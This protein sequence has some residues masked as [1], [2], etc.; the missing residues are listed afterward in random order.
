[1][2]CE[3]IQNFST[4]SISKTKN[5]GTGITEEEKIKVENIILRKLNLKIFI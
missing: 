4:R 1:M 2:A 5:N 3:L